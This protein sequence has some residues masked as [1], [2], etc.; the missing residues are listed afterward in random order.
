MHKLHQPG[1]WRF[2]VDLAHPKGKSMNDGIE[3]E[4]CSLRYTSVDEAVRRSMNMGHGSQSWT[5]ANK[6]T[7]RCDKAMQLMHSLFLF[8]AKYNLIL[9]AQHIPMCTVKKWQKNI[10]HSGCR[11]MEDPTPIPP[12]LLEALLLH[13]QDWTLQNWT[14]LHGEQ[15]AR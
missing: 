11:G 12:G 1:K 8:I 6:G 2:I 7:S 5:F 4:L 9:S 15:D 13:P 3:V 10:S 14:R